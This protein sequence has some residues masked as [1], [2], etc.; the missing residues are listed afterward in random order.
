MTGRRA[1]AAPTVSGVQTGDSVT[2]LTQQFAS[3]NVLGTNGSTLQVTGYTV[4]DGNGG[5]NYTVTLH[6]ALGTITQAALDIYATSQSKTYDVRRR[7]RTPTVSGL[8]P[9]DSVTGLVQVFDSRN[10]GSRTLSVTAYTVNDGNWAATTPSPRTRP[11]ARSASV[12]S[13]SPRRPTAR[14]TTGRRARRRPRPYSASRRR[15]GHRARAGLR[16]EERA[17]DEREHAAGDRVHGQRRQRRRQ[18]HRHPAHRE[19]HDHQGD[20][21]IYAVTDSKQYDG[22]TAPLRRRR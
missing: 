22:T 12:A 20:A 6:T 19:R 8:K 4:G 10:V 13:T 7:R 21:P 16:L 14:P 2:G 11:R 17:R 1:R 5:A 18:L 9:Y 15:H 3:K